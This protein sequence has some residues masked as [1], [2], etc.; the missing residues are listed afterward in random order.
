VAPAD[1]RPR[2]DRRI[3]VDACEI[4]ASG[5]RSAMQPA[6]AFAPCSRRRAAVLRRTRRGD[7]GAARCVS[8]PG[9]DEA[10]GTGWGEGI[11]FRD[12]EVVRD[13]NAPPHLVLHGAAA[14]MAR[15]RRIGHWHLTLTHTRTTAI[16][17]VL[18]ERAHRSR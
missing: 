17:W 4:A 16:A 13:G 15:R 18:C 7:S 6:R 10:L 9:G 14:R 1:R 3:G 5:V 2:R 8:P 12:V 11:G